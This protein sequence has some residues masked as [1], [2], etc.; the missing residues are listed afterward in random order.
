MFA[1]FLFFFLSWLLVTFLETKR[2]TEH[3][4][5]YYDI[6]SFSRGVVFF[7]FANGVTTARALLS[8]LS[9]PA[10]PHAFLGSPA[11]CPALRRLWL[12]S[13]RITVMEGLHHCGD[14]RELW[15]HGNR[16]AVTGG[17]ESLVHLKVQ[18]NK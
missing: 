4:G 2:T 1:F 15:L 12:F 5:E 6:N 3:C 17:L 16:I 8:Y 13:N 11:R 14:L 10:P 7:F 18:I 9:L